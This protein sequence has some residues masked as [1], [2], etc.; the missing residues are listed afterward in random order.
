MQRKAEEEVHRQQWTAYFESQSNTG[1][2]AMDG[3]TGETELDVARQSDA[4][5]ETV[6]VFGNIFYKVDD[7]NST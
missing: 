2:A 7:G 6:G 5:Q 3:E 4:G 1:P